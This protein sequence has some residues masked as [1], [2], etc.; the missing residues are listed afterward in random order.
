[1]ASARDARVAADATAH[2]PRQ[3]HDPARCRR[4]GRSRAR[5]PVAPHDLR[6][7]QRHAGPLRGRAARP[8]LRPHLRQQ[9]APR[10]A[11]VPRGRGGH[12]GP[13]RG[14]AARVHHHPRPARGR[15]RRHPQPARA[16]RAASTARS[17]RSRSSSPRWAPARSRP[18]DISAPADLEILNPELEIGN[19]E[20]GAPARHDP[21]DRPRPRLRPRRA[22]QGPGHHDRRHP[23]RLQLLAGPA[24]AL[25][26]QR[27]RAWASARTT[28]S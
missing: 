11:V 2:G 21:D 15:H 1:M 25:R 4:T 9:P 12:L 14:R 18:A 5:H 10:A 22:Q 20:A 23:G 17:A 8:R 24:R 6:A 16:G 3:Y 13:H 28:T 7:R 19:L 26:D 27:R